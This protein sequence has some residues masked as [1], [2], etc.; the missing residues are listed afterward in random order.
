MAAAPAAAKHML[1]ELEL[2]VGNRRQEEEE[3]ERLDPAEHFER[4][5]IPRQ[6]CKEIKVH[7]EIVQAG[8]CH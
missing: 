7:L 6:V 1:E 4:L 8:T 5:Y 3:P 2:G